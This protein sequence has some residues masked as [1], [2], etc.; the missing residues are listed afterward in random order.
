MEGGPE[1]GL[2]G[3]G[4]GKPDSYLIEHRGVGGPSA[5]ALG[6]PMCGVVSVERYDVVL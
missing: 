6:R 5:R 3:R 1:P 2:E 4:L